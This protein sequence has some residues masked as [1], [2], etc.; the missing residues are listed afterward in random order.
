MTKETNGTQIFSKKK[1]HSDIMQP[2]I[3]RFLKNKKDFS[4]YLLFS[5]GNIYHLR[6]K[7]KV[8]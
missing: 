2:I 1:M 5:D 4:L 6:E 7:E 8:I 3:G